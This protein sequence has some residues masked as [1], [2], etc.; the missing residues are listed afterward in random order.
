[1]VWR[2]GLLIPLRDLEPLDLDQLRLIALRPQLW[3]ELVN[4]NTHDPGQLGPVLKSKSIL[5]FR[6][7][8]D[9][10]WEMANCI[11][12]GHC[13]LMTNANESTL[14][15]WDIGIPGKGAERADLV[16]KIDL[17]KE[18]VKCQISVCGEH[19]RVVIG[20]LRCE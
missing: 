3:D 4:V 11:H 20:T 8:E 16:A 9:G 18:T 5:T 6:A 15:I 7:N 14:K 12:G 2:H 13:F 17:E 19:L 10:E 1:M